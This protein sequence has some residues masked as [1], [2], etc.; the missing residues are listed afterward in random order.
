MKGLQQFFR[1]RQVTEHTDI[2][3][4]S[5]YRNEI[6]GESHY[7]SDIRKLTRTGERVYRARV[8]LLPEPDN[9]HDSNAVRVTDFRGA[10]LGYLPRETA[11]ELHKAVAALSARSEPASCEA[12]IIGG[13]RERK[14]YGIWLDLS[15]RK[16]AKSV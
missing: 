15:A 13:D 3:S 16:L 12:I 10:T 9:P 14:H 4:G 6:V 8:L 1:R 5:N 11:A 2:S 7:Q